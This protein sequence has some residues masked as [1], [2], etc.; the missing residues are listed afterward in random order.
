MIRVQQMNNVR[1]FEN[2]YFF[3][4]SNLF[5]KRS[6]PVVCMQMTVL[7]CYFIC[8]E[9]STNEMLY[10]NTEYA[11]TEPNDNNYCDFVIAAFCYFLLCCSYL[12][13]NMALPLFLVAELGNV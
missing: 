11:V 7:Q 13:G 10:S 2:I 6:E 5:R 3:K 4:I 12:F 9:T 1:K 8:S